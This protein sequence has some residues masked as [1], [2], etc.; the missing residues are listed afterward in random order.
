MLH[1][2]LMRL[3]SDPAAFFDEFYPRV[4]RFIASASG[5]PPADVDDLV[6]ETLL[7]AW[8]NRGQFRG[9]ASLDSW[10]LAI[11]RNRIRM[12]RRADRSRD[13]FEAALKAIDHKEIPEDLARSAEAVGA[14]RRALDSLEAGHRDVLLRRYFQGL[15]IRLIAASLGETEKAIESRLH[16]AR[17]ALRDRLLQGGDDEL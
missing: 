1:I 17:E 13:E 5:A 2:A 11:A 12:R 3:E 8:R 7:N 14:V 15:P 6:Q 16:R 10:I 9:D 4:F